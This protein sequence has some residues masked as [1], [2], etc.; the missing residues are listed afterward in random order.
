MGKA[1]NQG[2]EADRADCHCTT[3]Q[4]LGIIINE[5]THVQGSWTRREG[6]S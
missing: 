3:K 2:Y 6:E 4:N 1:D 5:H